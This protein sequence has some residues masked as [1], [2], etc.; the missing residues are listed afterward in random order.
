MWPGWKKG[1]PSV[2]L[3]AT[4]LKG[5]P[6]NRFDTERNR[7]NKFCMVMQAAL[8]GKPKLIDLKKKIINRTSTGSACQVLVPLY[9]PT[10]G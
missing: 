10:V 7:R 8:G 9:L 6:Y 1:L 2:N 5:E 3:P 4:F